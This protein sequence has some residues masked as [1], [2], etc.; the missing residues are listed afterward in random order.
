[1]QK[2]QELLTILELVVNQFSRS[3]KILD[4]KFSLLCLIANKN[5]PYQYIK[6]G[7]PDYTY[8]DGKCYGPK[9][10]DCYIDLGDGVTVLM[11]QSIGELIDVINNL[12]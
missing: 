6:L 5:E 3:S 4:A 1:M 9:A 8:K 12:L 10:V 2:E 7:Q 11:S